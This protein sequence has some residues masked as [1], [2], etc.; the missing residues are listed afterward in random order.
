MTPREALKTYFGFDDFLEHQERIVERIL[1]GED[2]AVIMPTGAG[3]SICYQL[4]IL[5][6]SGYGI[7]ASPLIALM[8]DQ[9]ESL[10]RRG[11]AAE[12]I[13]ST[14]PLAR[15]EEIIRRVAAG[16]VKLLYVA[17]ERFGAG[18]FRAFLHRTPPHILVVDE[19]HCISQWGHDFR[20]AYRK[21]GQVAD[22]FN[23]GQVCAFTATATAAVREDIKKQLHRANM[24]IAAAGF[25]RPTLSFQ[26]LNCRRDQDKFQAIRRILSGNDAGATIIYAATRQAVED[27]VKEFGIT[28]YHAG[29]SDAD[30][31]AAQEYFMTTPAPVLAAT[32]AF[33]MGI[34]RADVR[35]VI[36]FQLPG[37]PEALYQEA[38]RAGRDG[39]PAECILLYNYADRY[40][41]Q[42]LLEMNNPPPEVI[43][44]VYDCLRRLSTERASRILEVRAAELQLLVPKS[45]G[46]GQISAALAALEHAGLIRRFATEPGVELQFLIAPAQLQIIHQG[47]ATQRSR[48][49]NRLCRRYGER[50][51]RRE[52]YALDELAAV[53]ALS[54]EQV[55][56]VLRALQGE[57][58]RYDRTF[59][60]RAIELL[61][62]DCAEVPLDD[63]ELRTKLDRE[64]ERL[65]A[66]ISYAE[67]PPGVC[68]QAQLLTYFGEENANWRC[69]CCDHCAATRCHLRRAPTPGEER[70]LR[71]ILETVQDFAGHIGAGK[72]AKLLAGAR[73]ADLASPYW[74]NHPRFGA[75]G[76]LKQTRILDFIRVLEGSGL[77]KRVDREGFPCLALADFGETT[78][79]SAVFPELELPETSA[80]AAS[81]CRTEKPKVREN[82]SLLELLKE[83]RRRIAE[84][85]HVALYQILPNSVLEELAAREIDDLDIARQLKGVGPVKAK[86]LLPAFLEAVRLY[87]LNR[88]QK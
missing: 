35:R 39:E 31:L 27:L 51:L 29:M 16:E 12:F 71:I 56:R 48:F 81:R 65:D 32:N 87:K 5:M 49:L 25:Q 41:Q 50:L 64:M 24:S 3:K 22:D 58:L 7:V 53:A 84:S 10:R 59:D 34:D 78:L 18:T 62:P 80:A 46:D 85:R 72:L 2:L 40:L 73:S 54:A 52:V 77:L 28:G 43:R 33:G 21:M 76:S 83:L 66:V 6:T 1:S 44:A 79:G 88:G 20:P 38:G 17:P 26:V 75:L 13:N 82:M 42:F 8:Q 11:I 4:P 23:I 9:V 19:A 55:R 45:A 74:R 68:R 67:S 15:Q 61:N 70:A 36:H 30:R 69:Q 14:V 57:A 86:K 47:E 37:S 60:G 63:A